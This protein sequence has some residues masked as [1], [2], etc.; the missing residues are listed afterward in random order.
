[1]IGSDLLALVRRRL[2]GPNPNPQQ[3]LGMT[4][5]QYYGG[6]ALAVILTVDSQRPLEI[7]RSAWEMAD[8]MLKTEK[9][10]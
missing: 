2:G 3:V 9:G 6:Q 1:M 5:R 7:A 8:A 4:L 10:E